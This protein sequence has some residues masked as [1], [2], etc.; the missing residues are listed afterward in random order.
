MMYP[1]KGYTLDRKL[2]VYIKDF[3]FIYIPPYDNRNYDIIESIVDDYMWVET[4]TGQ[5]IAIHYPKYREVYEGEY[6]KDADGIIRFINFEND[7]LPD[8]ITEIVFS[9]GILDYLFDG[10]RPVPI[11]E[12]EDILTVIKKDRMEYTIPDDGTGTRR[13]IIIGIQERDVEI[14]DFN[15]CTVKETFLSYQFDPAVPLKVVADH[16]GLTFLLARFLTN[17]YDIGFRAINVR[18]TINRVRYPDGTVYFRKRYDNQVKIPGSCI[19]FQDLGW[20]LINLLAI[21]TRI[22]KKHGRKGLNYALDFIPRAKEMGNTTD[23]TIC[24]ISGSLEY[25]ASQQLNDEELRN[26]GVKAFA[27]MVLEMVNNKEIQKQYALSEGAINVI[28]GS[29]NNWS[30]SARERFNALVTMFNEAMEILIAQSLGRDYFDIGRY[31]KHRNAVM[32]DAALPADIVV[33]N[34]ANVLRGL[35]YCSILSR[36]GVEKDMITQLCREGRINS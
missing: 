36:A 16:I 32:H 23:E 8:H 15:R 27:D 6:C 34:T 12:G 28:R 35:V 4:E 7:A 3:N 26:K 33:R 17:R 2:A 20:T 18:S 30:L 11:R 10:Q 22:I 24:S 19:T 9:G 25:E 14:N 5:R 21:F 1:I 13:K 31:V 29:I